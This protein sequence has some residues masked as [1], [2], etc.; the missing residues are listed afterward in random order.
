MSGLFSRIDATNDRLDLITDELI[1]LN[2]NV[3]QSNTYL[4]SIEVASVET[5][6]ILSGSGSSVPVNIT[7]SAVTVH[8]D[9]SF[10]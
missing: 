8:N 5:A 3:D 2:D 10:L 9:G 6:A 7:N 4:N 1:S